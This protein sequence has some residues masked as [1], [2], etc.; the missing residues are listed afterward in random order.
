MN[1]TYALIVEIILAKGGILLQRCCVKKKRA[2]NRET[3]QGINTLC[4]NVVAICHAKHSAGN[5]FCAALIYRNGLED[6]ICCKYGNISGIR[7]YKGIKINVRD[8]ASIF[9]GFYQDIAGTISYNGI[10]NC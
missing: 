8:S 9:L 2:V 7:P 4:S 10:I 1:I 3:G 6:V 5:G